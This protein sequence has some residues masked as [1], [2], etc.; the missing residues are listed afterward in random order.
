MFWPIG[1]LYEK[2]LWQIFL[3]FLEVLIF[4]KGGDWSG[5]IR[6]K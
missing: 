3:R 1:A 6:K 2:P 5:R 4:G